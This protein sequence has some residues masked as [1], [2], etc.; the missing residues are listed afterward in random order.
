M[1]QSSEDSFQK[2]FNAAEK[3][4]NSMKVAVEKPRTV[5][6]SVFG[7]GA[8]TDELQLQLQL[9]LGEIVLSTSN[10][11]QYKLSKSDNK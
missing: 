11:L 5:R 7:A 1:R 9:I 4:A 3:L 10:T 8:I 2:I 6:R